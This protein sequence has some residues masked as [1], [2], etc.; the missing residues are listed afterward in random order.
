MKWRALEDDWCPVARTLSLVGDRWTL[1]ILRDC[2]L[3]QTRFEA[4]ARST[5][6]TRHIIADRLKRLVTAG[7]LEQKAYQ[8]RPVRYDYVL[9]ERGKE[10]APALETFRDWGRTHLP[11]R[12]SA[13][14]NAT[15]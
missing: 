9:T 3:G 14:P 12:R 4:F 5:G 11:I 15:E 7:L 6:A 10:L 13:K 2:F 1:L 8:Q